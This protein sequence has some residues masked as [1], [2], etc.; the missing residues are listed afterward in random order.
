MRNDKA[1]KPMS[2]D[3]QWEAHELGFVRIVCLQWQVSYNN[4]AMPRN[5]T[6]R[7]KCN[8]EKGDLP[9]APVPEDLSHE[10]YSPAD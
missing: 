10:E 3:Q 2:L 9:M 6:A 7:Q 5:K 8:G 1:K 4:G